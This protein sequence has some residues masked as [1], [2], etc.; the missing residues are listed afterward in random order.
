MTSNHHG[1]GEWGGCLFH[2][3]WYSNSTSERRGWYKCYLWSC[4]LDVA[5]SVMFSAWGTATRGGRKYA[6]SVGEDFGGGGK[7]S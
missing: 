2:G 7:C 4:R 5:D 1:H 3:A 6:W